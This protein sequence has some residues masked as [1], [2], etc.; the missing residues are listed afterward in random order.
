MSHDYHPTSNSYN[1]N[2]N[3]N[4]SS[5][6][7]GAKTLLAEAREE[8]S[9][10]DHNRPLMAS[11]TPA[12]TQTI[13]TAKATAFVT[14][15]TTK[16]Q[17]PQPQPQPQNHYYHYS[18]SNRNEDKNRMIESVVQFDPAAAN[19]KQN[20]QDPSIKQVATS[21]KSLN[22]LRFTEDVL[23]IDHHQRHYYNNHDDP[24]C[25]SPISKTIPSNNYNISNGTSDSC[26]NNSTAELYSN[27][28]SPV[29]LFDFKPEESDFSVMQELWIRKDWTDIS[30]RIAFVAPIVLLG[31]LGNLTIIY[32]MCKF[33][34]FRSKPTNIFILNMAVADLLT[35]MVCPIAA[36]VKDIYQFYV[37]GSF[38]CR[39]EGFVKS[40]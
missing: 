39:F 1:S 36:L 27:K 9:A 14:T 7:A 5:G 13:T 10:K 26:S 25:E 38:I 29:G 34:N 18:T 6:G 4:G 28:I 8:H 20:L 40:K 11:L 32:S 37:L 3:S 12:Q 22:Q 31:I 35:T 15:T 33:K 23:F 21:Q 24:W 2:N 16:Q 19:S 17:Q 30:I